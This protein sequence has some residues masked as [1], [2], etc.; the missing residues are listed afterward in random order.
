MKKYKIKIPIYHAYLAII[1]TDSIKKVAEK[2]NVRC[3]NNPDDYS[4]DA[5]TFDQPDKKGFT[6]YYYVQKK[7]VSCGVI[8][9]EAK[10]LVNRIFR[11]R[12]IE[13]S[14]INDESECYLLGWI[15]NKIIE[16]TKK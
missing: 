9:H 6:H 8:A 12:G 14:V 4:Y 7:S 1:K 11:D 2:Y 3:V 13:L 16:Y 15:V 5:I 10:H